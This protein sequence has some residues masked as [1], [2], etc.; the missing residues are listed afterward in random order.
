MGDE[1]VT[2]LGGRGMLG[3]ALALACRDKYDLKV[4]D[5]PDF[6]IT[7]RRQLEEVVRSSLVIVNCAA[8]TD[9]DGAEANVDLAYRVNGEAVGRLGDFAKAAGVWVLH[10]STDFVFDG[11]LDRPYVEADPP[12]PINTYGKSKL[13]GERLLV[14]SGCRPCI[15]RV[16]WT[17]GPHGKNFVTKI[18]GLARSKRRLRVVD[19]QIGSPTATTEAA[20]AIVEL[21]AK[22]PEGV[23]HFASAGYVSRYE[24]AR[25]ICEKLKMEVEVLPCSSSEFVTPAKRPL[26]SRFECGKIKSLLGE[27]IERWEEPLENFLRQL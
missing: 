13:A 15:M 20:R 14:E 9:V 23:F 11:R 7:N 24:M 27:R 4:L 22:R 6:D 8:Y 5:L 18:A 10:I 1:Q 17:Y 16:Q 25:F 2:I 21:L 26:N 12:N 3:S 19:D